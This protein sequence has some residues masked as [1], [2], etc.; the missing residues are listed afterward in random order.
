[1]EILVR[2]IISIISTVLSI[3][4][5][6]I[7]LRKPLKCEFQ[8]AQI[9]SRGSAESFTNSVPLIWELSELFSAQAVVHNQI[10]KRERVV[11]HIHKGDD[12]IVGVSIFVPQDN[13]ANIVTVWS[14]GTAYWAKHNE[15]GNGG[16]SQQFR[17]ECRNVVLHQL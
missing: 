8:S 13:G 6:P 14:N 7:D 12:G 10:K 11:R 16:A 1:M 4:S 3:E 2:S 9:L 15:A 5:S 17:G